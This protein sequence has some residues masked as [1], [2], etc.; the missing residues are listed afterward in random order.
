YPPIFENVLKARSMPEI[1]QFQFQESLA[2]AS[3]TLRGIRHYEQ[4]NLSRR[5]RPEAE[6]FMQLIQT[7]ADPASPARALLTHCQS[8]T[9]PEPM[10]GKAKVRVSVTNTSAQPRT[11]AASA[12]GS[13]DVSVS[14]S[15]E[16]H[17]SLAPK[18]VATAE[19][20]VALP[21]DAKPGF[22]HVFVRFD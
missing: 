3:R 1:Y 16:D 10:Q 18:G 2:M 5:P 22:Y 20:N 14:L 15:G 4:L 19:L 21:A 8:V 6:A 13:G 9:M 17:F 11:V 7:Y 12:E